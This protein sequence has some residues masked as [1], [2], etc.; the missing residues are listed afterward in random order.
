MHAAWFSVI[1]GSVGLNGTELYGTAHDGIL[2][3]KYS[4]Y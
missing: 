4:Y 3:K 1:S 2:E